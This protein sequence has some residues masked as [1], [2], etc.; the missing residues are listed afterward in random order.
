MKGLEIS[1]FLRSRPP[2]R[3]F[4][5]ALA[6]AASLAEKRRQW[7]AGKY[8]RNRARILKRKRD[9]KRRLRAKQKI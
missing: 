6:V 5:P 2:A 4:D 3:W 7:N 8:Q 1:R 9:Q